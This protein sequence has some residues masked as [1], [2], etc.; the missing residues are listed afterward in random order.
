MLINYS[1]NNNGQL[2]EQFKKE[3]YLNMKEVQNYIPIYDLYFSLNENNYNSINLNQYNKLEG[4]SLNNKG[5]VKNEL[6]DLVEKDVFFKFSPLLDPVKYLTGKYN[7]EDKNLFN[8]PKYGGGECH[9]KILDKNNSAYVDAF[10]TYLISQLLHRHKFI[11]G[12]DYYGSYLGIKKNF[13][14]DIIDDIE[15]LYDSDYFKNNIAN[16]Y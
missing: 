15:Y 11:N 16:I 5:E 4:V 12:L 2:F 13:E 6:N 1:K 8:L 10:A 14:L 7:T 9:K 3:E